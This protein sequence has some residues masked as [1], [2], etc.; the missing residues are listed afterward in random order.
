MGE[1]KNIGITLSTSTFANVPTSFGS[2]KAARK[3]EPMNTG[4]RAANSRPIPARFLDLLDFLPGWQGSGALVS[5]SYP[6][7]EAVRHS[8]HLESACRACMGAMI[9]HGRDSFACRPPPR[10]PQVNG[11]A[12]PSPRRRYGIAL[13]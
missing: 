10:T 9:I 4:A 13:G 11:H 6:H 2:R 7:S 12:S 3:D 5:P 8:I 1:R